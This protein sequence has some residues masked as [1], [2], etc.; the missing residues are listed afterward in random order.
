[1]SLS[2]ISSPTVKVRRAL[3]VRDW[4]E[5]VKLGDAWEKEVIIN[6]IENKQQSKIKRVG[7]S[8]YQNQRLSLQWSSQTT[9]T[10][11][12]HHLCLEERLAGVQRSN[13][14][15]L[16]LI[17]VNFPAS[18]FPSQKESLPGAKQRCLPPTWRCS[19]A[20]PVQILFY[21]PPRSFRCILRL[22][23]NLFHWLLE[24]ILCV[25]L[26]HIN[27]TSVHISL[28][29]PPCNKV[30]SLLKDKSYNMKYTG[31]HIPK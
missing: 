27:R 13:V 24:K 23:Q 22:G 11:L 16:T 2:Y 30:S 28:E 8:D 31:G 6:T 21:F 20:P 14:W 15:S 17:Q 3:R 5:V 1:M 9:Q 26:Q 4:S 19:P 12:I 18:P 10:L 7:F 29:C 25:A